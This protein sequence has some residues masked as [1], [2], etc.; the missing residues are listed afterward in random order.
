[1]R[2]SCCSRR[3]AAPTRRAAGG[4]AIPSDRRDAPTPHREPLRRR[5]RAA[6]ARATEPRRAAERAVPRPPM[7]TVAASD[8]S[9]RGIRPTRTRPRHPARG[10]TPTSTPTV[11]LG[12]RRPQAAPAGRLGRCSRSPSSS[13][14]PG[15]I[16]GPCS[17][18]RPNPTSRRASIVVGADREADGLHARRGVRHPDDARAVARVRHPRGVGRRARRAARRLEAR[19]RR[20][21]RPHAPAA[22]DA[23]RRVVAADHQ[24][25]PGLPARVPRCRTACGMRSPPASPRPGR[26]SSSSTTASTAARSSRRSA[27]RSCR[28]DDEHTLHERIKPV[29]R[30][31]LIDVVRRIATGELDLAAAAALSAAIRHRPRSPRSPHGRPQPRPVP[32]PRPRRRSHPARARL[33]ERQDRPADDSPRRSPAPASRSSRPARPPPPSAT[34]ASR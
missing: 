12:P 2:P 23:R 18:R 20:A 9:R 14:A 33:G 5:R 31:L 17:M 27:C 16:C 10:P 13:R 1:M 8:A 26:A 25:P 22:G 29:E 3:D 30:R 6:D 19:S 7:P 15:P 4:S 11:D 34:P 21:E 28:G 24:H 32:V